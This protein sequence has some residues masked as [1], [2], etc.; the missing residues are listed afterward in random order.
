LVTEDRPD[1][2]TLRSPSNII[3]R[4]LF[5]AYF[6][7][8]QVAAHE[9]AGRWALRLELKGPGQ[10]DERL[11]KNPNVTRLTLHRWVGLDSRQLIREIHM[12]VLIPPLFRELGLAFLIGLVGC[13]SAPPTEAISNAEITIRKANSMGAAEHTPLE[14]QVAIKKLEL[15]NQA[16][17]K[18]ENELARRLAEEAQIDGELAEAMTRAAQAHQKADRVRKTRN[19]PSD[20]PSAKPEV[21]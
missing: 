5:V 3:G 6:A 8:R 19:A 10:L 9:L 21:E 14:L 16:L 17:K 12:S 2:G 13:A 20:E 11:I 18:G 7:Y 4:H 1:K 15:A